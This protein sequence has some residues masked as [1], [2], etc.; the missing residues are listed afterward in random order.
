MA[1]VSDE[2]LLQM[3]LVHGGV[4]GAAAACGLSKAAIYKRLE[5]PEFRNQYDAMQG[6]LL[7]TAAASMADA[8]GSAVNTLRSV[9]E[10]ASAASGTRVAAADALLRHTCRYVELGSVL[11]RIEALEEAQKQEGVT[12]W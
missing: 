6:V 2:K 7:A 10:D 9:L 12:D 3:L 11:R 1:K 5:V 8:V 4:S